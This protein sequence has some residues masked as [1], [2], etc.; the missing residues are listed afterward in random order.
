MK[1]T[2]TQII[3]ASRDRVWTGLND[4]D[5]LRQCIPGCSNIERLSPT[6]FRATVTVPLGPLKINF[7]GQILLSNLNPPDSYRISGKG[8]GGFAGFAAGG[9]DIR[10]TAISA[11][12]TQMD[13]D[14]DAQIGGKLAKFGSKLVG[15]TASSLTEKFFTKFANLINAE[16]VEPSASDSAHAKPTPLL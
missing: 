15:S 9:A 5:I 4:P 7:S 1:L 3:P 11:N 16:D 14:A 13:Y 2:G 8:E 12:E 6:D 10:L